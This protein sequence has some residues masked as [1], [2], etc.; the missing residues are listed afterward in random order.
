MPLIDEYKKALKAGQKDYRSHLSRGLY[1][2]LPSLEESL[3]NLTGYSCENPGVLQLPCELLIGTATS[4]RQTAFAPNFMPLLDTDTEF[5]HK[6]IDLCGAHLNEGIREPVK[7]YE[8]M[9]H[10]YVLEGNKR[11]S[12]LKYFNAP[13]F[14]A[15][16]TR[17][18]PPRDDSY[19]NQLYYEYL[20]FYRQSGAVYLILTRLGDYRRLLLLLHKEASHV[21]TD[22]EKLVFRSFF[23][24]F[25]EAFYSLGGKKLSITTGD[26]ILVYLKIYSC[27]EQEKDRLAPAIRKNLARIWDDVLL[28]SRDNS[29][30][31]LMEPAKEPVYNPLK[32]LL[33]SA[34]APHIRAAFLYART[35]KTSRWSYSHELGRLYLEQ[36]FPGQLT[37]C[38]YDHVTEENAQAVMAEA[39][40]D[41]CNVLFTTAADFIE[42]SLLTAIDNPK[43]RVLN[44]SL[45][46]SHRYIRTYYGRMYEAMFLVG[47]IAGSVSASGRIGYVADY[48]IYGMVANINAFA[49]GASLVNPRAVIDLQWSTVPGW[50]RDAF[51]RGKESVFLSGASQTSAQESTEEPAEKTDGLAPGEYGLYRILPDS[52]GRMEEL[53]IPLWHWG[54]FYEL[55]IRSILDG[56]W[57]TDDS[58]GSF[59]ALNYWWGLSAGVVDVVCSRKLSADTEKLLNLL[60]NSICSGT[61]H[62]F[63]GPLTSQTGQ[64]LP[65]GSVP[66]PVD[67]ITMDWLADNVRGRIPDL[68]ELTEQA[69]PLVRLQGVG[70]QEQQWHAAGE[71][72]V[73]QSTAFMPLPKKTDESKELL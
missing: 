29:A 34:S 48:P 67:I 69:R 14:P 19:E 41:G 30:A 16:V 44:C 64:I 70:S 1:P 39:I 31:L 33:A 49:L 47:A 52:E 24:R 8:Y 36:A 42:P 25:E 72:K 12:V 46:C 23:L 10:Y 65:A 40:A 5:A 68:S 9:N 18:L 15:D 4:G 57:T 2:Y 37:T 20:D 7:V 22:E 63:A 28:R 45:N 60:R 73:R 54:R 62:P 35:P 56:T 38:A 66:E 50:D 53:A 11:V 61:L 21:W 58:S 6:W 51:C 59:Q 55:L 13:S 32:S 3:P 17:I 71:K 26:A 43:V 27:Y